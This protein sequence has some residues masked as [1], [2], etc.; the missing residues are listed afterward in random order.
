MVLWIRLHRLE[1]ADRHDPPCWIGRKNEDR[2]ACER[3]IG[4]NPE[5]EKRPKIPGLFMIF[6]FGFC[7]WRVFEK[8]GFHPLNALG[9]PANR[10]FGRVLVEVEKLPRRGKRRP[11]LFSASRSIAKYEFPLVHPN[12]EHTG[13]G[14]IDHGSPPNWPG[15]P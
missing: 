4:P 3:R 6:I 15:L 2:A 12:G 1:G 13:S 11:R 5:E 14:M 7:R 8:G 10:C 9:F